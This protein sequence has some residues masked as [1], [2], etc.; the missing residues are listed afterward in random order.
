MR[1]A[2]TPR[3][4]ALPARSARRVA[5]AATPRDGAPSRRDALV[6]GEWD[7]WGV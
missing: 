3:S 5:A 1:T 2:T 6:S 7:P 4:S